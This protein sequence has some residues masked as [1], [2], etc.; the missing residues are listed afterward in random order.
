M[1]YQHQYKTSVKLPQKRID[2]HPCN[3]EYLI[4]DFQFG[5]K[6]LHF[7]NHPFR[8]SVEVPAYYVDTPL[9]MPY[10]YWY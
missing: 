2:K 7:A 4:A 8:S 9:T 1:Y 5:G 6:T 3:A 10:Q